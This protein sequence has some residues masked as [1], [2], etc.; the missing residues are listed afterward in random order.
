LLWLLPF[1]AWNFASGTHLLVAPFAILAL[2]V[3]TARRL[4]GVA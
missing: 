2:L 4:E 3:M 1:A